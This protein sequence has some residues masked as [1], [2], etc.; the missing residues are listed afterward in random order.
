MGMTGVILGKA[1]SGF[2]FFR[3]SNRRHRVPGGNQ[4]EIGRLQAKSRLIFSRAKTSRASHNNDR[5]K[6]RAP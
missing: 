2:T 3:P 6:P 5:P 1:L 4:E